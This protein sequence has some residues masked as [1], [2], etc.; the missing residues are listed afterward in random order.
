SAS[1]SLVVHRYCFAIATTDLPAS[2]SS[3]IVSSRSSWS[4]QPTPSLF[5]RA[6][7]TTEHRRKHALRC[8]KLVEKPPVMDGAPMSRLSRQRQKQ[9]RL[10]PKSRPQASGRSHQGGDTPRPVAEPMATAAREGASDHVQV[11]A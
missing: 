11:R 2:R 7:R 8:D 4:M 6:D 3:N 5:E 10:R 9:P 1:T